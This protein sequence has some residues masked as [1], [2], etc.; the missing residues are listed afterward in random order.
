MIFS[1]S[2]D[3]ENKPLKL[4]DISKPEPADGEVLIKIT[5]SG[6]CHTDLDEIEGRLAAT[7]NP[8]IPGHQVVGV[9]EQIGCNVDSFKV[10]D[11]VGVTW[12][13]SSCGNCRYCKK[14]LEN[15]CSQAKWT[16]KDAPGG[17]AEYMVV[18]GSSVFRVPERYTDVQAAPL[19]CAGV[20]GYRALRLCDVSDGENIALFGF[21]ASAHI[22]LQVIKNIYPHSE[23]FVFTRSKHHK[24]L[25]ESLGASWTG[26]AGEDPGV[27]IDKAIDFTPVCTIIPQVMEMLSPAGT[28]VINA[29]R[30]IDTTPRLDYTKHLWQEKQIRSTANVT[31]AD[32]AE[33]LQAASDIP[34]TSEYEIFELE[35]ANEAL[36]AMKTS[37]LRAAAVLKI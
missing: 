1:E 21:G 30:K 32:A 18:P 25:A 24:E 10:G 19:L 12:F 22:V 3:I 28:L 35:Q 11:R 17:Y 33:F 6:C 13:F 37:K 36:I 7:I 16:G 29:I 31:R 23:V 8:V 14:G 20:I 15:L 27:S 9:V 34:I 26:S 5:A 4:V 2:F